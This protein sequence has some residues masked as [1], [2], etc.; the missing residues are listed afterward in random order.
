MQNKSNSHSLTVMY[1]CNLLYLCEGP[2][3]ST[4]PT[5]L[6]TVSF[7]Q[8]QC[9]KLTEGHND[10]TRCDCLWWTQCLLEQAVLIHAAV[11]GQNIQTLQRAVC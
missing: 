3:R 6:M 7:R 8:I 9:Y 5:I 10:R 11:V 2:Y 4:A 1:S